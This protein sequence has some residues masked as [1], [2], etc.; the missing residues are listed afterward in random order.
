MPSL[1]DLADRIERLLLRHQELK[2]TNVLLEQQLATIAGER[3]SL[4]ARLN[5]ARGRIDALLD[6]LPSDHS[7]AGGMIDEAGSDAAAPGS[8]GGE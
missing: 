6:R 3:D 7:N 8:E 5:T 4:R 2:R 1:E